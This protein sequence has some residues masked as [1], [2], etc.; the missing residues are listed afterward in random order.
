MSVLPLTESKQH[1]VQLISDGAVLTFS[2]CGS[3][4]DVLTQLI[5]IMCPA[6]AGIQLLQ[7]DGAQLAQALLAQPRLLF[8]TVNRQY[9]CRQALETR[10]QKSVGWRKLAI[11][12]NQFH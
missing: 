4:G 5:L 9:I 6:G 11:P 12:L 2:V 10:T 1:L 3:G 7:H 8:D